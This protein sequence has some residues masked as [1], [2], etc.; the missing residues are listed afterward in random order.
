MLE[1][2]HAVHVR[3]AGRER[4]SPTRSSCAST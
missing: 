3:S 4:T 1:P 2:R